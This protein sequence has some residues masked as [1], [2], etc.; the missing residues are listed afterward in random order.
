MTVERADAQGVAAWSTHH[1]A[2][3]TFDVVGA[4]ALIVLFSPVLLMAAILISAHDRGPVLFRQPRVGRD[5]ELFDCLKL[6]SMVVGAEAMLPDLLVQEG[7]T[8]GLFKMPE[9][10][11]ITRPGRWLRRFSVDELP[12]LVNV[13]RGQMSLVGPRPPLPTEA[14]A[15]TVD[16][17]RRL[18]VRPGMT[19]LWQVS[20]RSEL[21]WD[22]AIRLDLFYVD[23]W[24]LLQDMSILLRTF[25]AVLGRRGAY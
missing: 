21:S 14:A 23:N 10:P 22:E 1:A 9:D 5:G 7:H 3:R 6:R 24:S 18:R 25:R 11:R 20:G 2:K 17:Q 8:Q 19:G 15:Y 13:I 12:Q 4:L 16:M